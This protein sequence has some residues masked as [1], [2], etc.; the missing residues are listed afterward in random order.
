MMG[1][2]STR[3]AKEQEQ[4][5]ELLSAYL[6]NQLSAGERARLEAQLATDPALRAELDALRQTV[7][8]VRDLPPVPIPR[9]FI[10]PHKVVARSR[11][12]RSPRPRGAWAAPLLTAATAV[13]SLLFVVV[14]AGDL[15]LSRGVG[16]ALVPAAELVAEKEVP[17]PQ[18]LAPS[19]IREGVEAEKMTL[20]ATP[21]PVPAE[22]PL[23][24]PP[25]AAAETERYAAEAPEDEESA[26]PTA[27]GGP[28]EEPAALPGPP[29]AEE[30]AAAST[31]PATSEGA[32]A[33]VPGT[34]GGGQGGEPTTPTPAPVPTVA[35]QVAASPTVPAAAT[36]VPVGEVDSAEP[37]PGEATES[38]TWAAEEQEPDAG[39]G[40]RG[41]ALGEGTGLGQDWPWQ[42]LEVILGLV[43]LGLALVTIWAW[44]VRRR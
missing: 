1:R 34:G 19:P 28:V 39:E 36:A 44:R 15:L 27:N 33:T 6:D 42:A 12:S 31:A 40:E 7:A 43:A 9:N 17:Q 22:T 14:L 41:A 21:L 35:R 11:P 23:E 37:A 26:V 16:S 10:L 25:E 4:R 3:Q 38:P 32:D 13:V 24:A 29:V 5:D 8:L 30:I 2:L 20:T 18:A